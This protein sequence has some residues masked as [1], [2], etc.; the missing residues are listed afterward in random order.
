MFACEIAAQ[1][2]EIVSREGFCFADLVPSPSGVQSQD[3]ATKALR[4]QGAETNQ[5]RQET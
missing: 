4:Q 3:W 1:V 2:G 5:A